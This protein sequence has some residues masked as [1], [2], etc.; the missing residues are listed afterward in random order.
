MVFLF[1]WGNI[2]VSTAFYTLHTLTQSSDSVVPSASS[3][4]FSLPMAGFLLS[5]LPSLFLCICISVC[6]WEFM[7]LKIHVH[8]VRVHIH[9]L[10]FRRCP[11]CFTDRASHEPASHQIRIAICQPLTSTSLCL[12]STG[13]ARGLV[14]MV[15]LELELGFTLTQ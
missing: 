15:V 1:Y 2:N 9:M 13:M 7:F 4:N 6:T 3:R 5:F 14:S 10:F 11:P 8:M 12:L